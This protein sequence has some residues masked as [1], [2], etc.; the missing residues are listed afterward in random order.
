MDHTMFIGGR[1][2]TGD[3]MLDVINPA[4]EEPFA[5]VPRAR[6]TQFGEALAAATQAQKAWEATPIAPRRTSIEAVKNSPAQSSE[7]SRSATSMISP[8]APMHPRKSLERSA[9]RLKLSA[10]RAAAR[11]S[12]HLVRAWEERTSRW[13]T[14]RQLAA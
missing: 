7:L 6:R 14:A 11:F 4:T 3:N 10:G 8:L 13:Q 9:I 2:V 5:R 1:L 12:R